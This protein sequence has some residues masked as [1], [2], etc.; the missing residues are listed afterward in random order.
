MAAF[1]KRGMKW[2]A[3]VR[4]RGHFQS[5]V[6]ETK[7][8]AQ[9]WAR[10]IEGDLDHGRAAGAV[11][12]RHTLGDLLGRYEVER[13]KS[14]PIRRSLEHIL[15]QLDKGL[16][17]VAL[18]RFTTDHVLSYCA[19]R[20]AAGAGPVTVGMDLSILGSVVRSAHGIL[21]V[22]VSDEPVQEARAAL[23]A[24]RLIR[25]SRRRERRPSREEVDR[26]IR[27]F[28]DN[29]RQRVPMWDIIE[30]AIASAMRREEML[31]IAWGDLDEAGRIVLIR[32]RKDPEEKEGNDELVPLLAVTG[33]DA[34]E[35]IR[36]QPR[37]AGAIFPYSPETVTTIF[38]RA[39]GALGI[40]D[41]RFHDLRHEGVSRM[42]EA[43]MSIE[44][45]A[46]CSGHK[47]WQT[48]RRYT[49]IKGA[50]LARK[51]APAAPSASPKDRT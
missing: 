45:V 12:T 44:E 10:R 16:G 40:E 5:A 24:A 14:K 47:N 13:R 42:F 29:P 2:Q 34:L 8:A 41:L 22:K 35:L 36:K 31:R 38:A 30:F 39:C 9:K 25:K 37:G 19:A 20:R 6:F 50:D 49:H 27:H 11:R 21:G 15:G 4:R 1:R 28:R 43:G 23:R 46:I 18:A 51:Y 17:Q 32:D 3:Q 33:Y 7:A 48:L 26:L